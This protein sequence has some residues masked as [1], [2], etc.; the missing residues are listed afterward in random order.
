MNKADTVLVLMAHL[1]SVHKERMNSETTEILLTK[2]KLKV[3]FPILWVLL[4]QF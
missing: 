4:L 2:P 3:A 1:F